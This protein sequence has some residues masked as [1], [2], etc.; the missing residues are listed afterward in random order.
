MNYFLLSLLLDIVV[1]HLVLDLMG[2]LVLTSVVVNEDLQ[3]VPV[4]LRDGRGRRP[5]GLALTH[6]T[7]RVESAM[8]TESSFGM[9]QSW[10]AFRPHR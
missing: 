2:K 10:S 1:L 8:A 9:E 4:E 3:H 5:E 6:S 7:L